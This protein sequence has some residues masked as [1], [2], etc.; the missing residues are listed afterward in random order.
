[1]TS[2]KLEVG[3]WR[4]AL[5]ILHPSFFRLTRST[6]LMVLLALSCPIMPVIAGTQATVSQLLPRIVIVIAENAFRD[7]EFDVPFKY[8]E[9]RALA[10]VASTKLGTITGML[11][12]KAESQA[13]LK[14]IDIDRLDA[15]V[16]IGGAGA[17]Q[18]W[19]DPMA[20]KLVREAVAK[21][22]VLGAI[23]ISPVT[24]AYAGVLRGKRATVWVSERSRLIEKGA[25]YTGKDV[26]ID[27]LI[28]TADGPPAARKFAEAILK[29]VIEQAK[30]RQQTK[31][32]VKEQAAAAA[33][34]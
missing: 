11:G 5:L 14:D 22:K 31:E 32:S 6:V 20:H 25:K 26:T 19:R 29:L 9:G 33:G 8:F 12:H 16:F 30:K 17:R 23:C 28:V 4:T 27:G 18:Y 3:S 13:L 34:K 10:T 24:L 21:G 1:M 7:E 2:W 15:L